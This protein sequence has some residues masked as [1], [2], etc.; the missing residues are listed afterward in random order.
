MLVLSGNFDN[1]W[2]VFFFVGN[3]NFIFLKFQF[4]FHNYSKISG[5]TGSSL[6]PEKHEMTKREISLI[7][8][9]WEAHSANPY[10]TGSKLLYNFFESSSEVQKK[11][12]K[13]REIPLKDLKS[14]INFRELGKK[15][16]LVFDQVVNAL[17]SRDEK[18]WEIVEQ[19]AVQH[20]NLGITNKQYFV[21]FRKIIDSFLRLRGDPKAAWDAFLDNFFHHFFGKL[22]D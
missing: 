16:V 18:P 21:D 9:T 4:K 2:L 6:N 10:E 12:Q 17:G 3:F 19:I 11:F 20:R 7:K 8:K 5:I 15:I 14:D 13:F 22:S 1:F